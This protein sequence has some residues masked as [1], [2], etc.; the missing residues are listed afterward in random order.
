MSGMRAGD[1]SENKTG[2]LDSSL[3]HFPPHSKQTIAHRAHP[4]LLGT[5]TYPFV[6]IL[7][8]AAFVLQGGSGVVMTRDLV[9]CKP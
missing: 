8:L 1:L 6:Y 9:S 4:V 3:P 5:Q 7:S 2:R